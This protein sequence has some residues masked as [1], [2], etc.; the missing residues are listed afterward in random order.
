[1]TKEEFREQLGNQSL[2][3]VRLLAL[4]KGVED[5]YKIGKT[6]SELIENICEKYQ[7]TAY[8]NELILRAIQE[9]GELQSNAPFLKFVD[10]ALSQVNTDLSNLKGQFESRNEKEDAKVD[11]AVSGVR[12]FSLV[13]GAV[14]SVTAIFG[15]TSVLDVRNRE[16]ELNKL[17]DEW[18]IELTEATE[19]HKRH[20]DLVIRARGQSQERFFVYVEAKNGQFDNALL[21]LLHSLR[22]VR[23]KESKEILSNMNHILDDLEVFREVAKKEEIL[24]T[25]QRSIKFPAK[26]E[27]QLK[28]IEIIEDY[29]NWT[30]VEDGDKQLKDYDSIIRKIEK[31]K[32]SGYFLDR[33]EQINF[34]RSV[35]YAV[36]ND[37]ENAGVLGGKVK[38]EEIQNPDE[39]FSRSDEHRIHDNS[40]KGLVYL[41]EI[42][43]HLL[44]GNVKL[45]VWELKK[46]KKNEKVDDILDLAT[47]AI[48]LCWHAKRTLRNLD[49]NEEFEGLLDILL[50]RSYSLRVKSWLS[51]EEEIGDNNSIS[52]FGKAN[53]DAESARH[54]FDNRVDSIEF[55]NF[56]TTLNNMAFLKMKQAVDLW[57]MEKAVN[58]ENDTLFFGGLLE[59]ASDLIDNAIEIS[60]TDSDLE[61]FYLTKVEIESVYLKWLV[62][63]G[64]DSTADLKNRKKEDIDDLLLE[65]IP[66]VSGE[67]A[68]K[69]F[70]GK[71]ADDVKLENFRWFFRESCD[72]DMR[73]KLKEFYALED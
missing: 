72:D 49:S 46:N 27:L 2:E 29:V 24:E 12:F 9:V 18:H 47:A 17:R 67:L 20:T 44:A 51:K 1:M 21:N 71:K 73:A 58:Q 48:G 36:N 5:A 55:K 32:P 54:L 33:Y 68:V 53:A 3:V 26:I 52:L 63:Q 70:K 59:E 56:A 14:F 41:S 4:R 60:N 13:L 6:R 50:L 7:D 31:F 28:L 23:V 25:R 15:I 40:I 64:D 38:L 8:D 62:D 37:N 45:S 34:E 57:K 35:G 39:S 10:S 61:L 65:K 22:L 66:K 11:E 16:A 69:Y 43:R 19:L 30:N 42:S